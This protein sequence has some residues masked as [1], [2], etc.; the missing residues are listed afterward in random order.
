MTLD[1]LE[2]KMGV[3]WIFRRF[4]AATHF[5]SGS[6][7]ARRWRHLA[8]VNTSYPM[9]VAG[10]MS[11]NY[12]VRNGPSNMHRCRTFPFALAGLFCFNSIAKH[13]QLQA[14]AYTAFNRS[15]RRSS[16]HRA[17][18]WTVSLNAS[19]KQASL[20]SLVE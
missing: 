18:N 20:Q 11:F 6:I 15:R 10:S 13:K 12:F 8:Y 3:L 2:R 5:K 17:M 1:D 9:S 7:H 14:I 16:Q 4:W 19:L